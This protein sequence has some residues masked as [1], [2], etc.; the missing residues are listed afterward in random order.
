MLSSFV[1][2]GVLITICIM[3]VNHDV[4]DIEVDFYTKDPMKKTYVSSI[5]IFLV[6]V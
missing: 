3:G 1:D 4:Y 6:M 5:Y 2:S